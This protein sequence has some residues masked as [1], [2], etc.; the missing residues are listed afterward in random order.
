MQVTPAEIWNVEF[1]KPNSKQTKPSKAPTKE[2]SVSSGRN[3]ESTQDMP[4][5]PAE[6]LYTS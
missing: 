4:K 1:V 6:I 5:I 2:D 3:A